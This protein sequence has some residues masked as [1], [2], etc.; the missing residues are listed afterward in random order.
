MIDLAAM[1]QFSIFT[2]IRKYSLLIMSRHLSGITMV[3]LILP[4][5]LSPVY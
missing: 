1:A 5:K 4:T 3:D 2:K